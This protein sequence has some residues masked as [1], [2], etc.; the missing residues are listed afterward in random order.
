VFPHDRLLQIRR[1]SC[2][3]KK[4][5]LYFAWVGSS[6]K[7][8]IVDHLLVEKTLRDEVSLSQER[9]RLLS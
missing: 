2:R 7:K 8:A 5:I 6:G 9:A 3:R 1:E 4:R